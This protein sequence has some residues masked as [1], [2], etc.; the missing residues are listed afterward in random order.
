MR[1]KAAPTITGWIIGVLVELPGEPAPARHFFAVAQP[2]RA[3]AEWAAAD[4]AMLIGAI[5][6]SPYRS[7]EPVDALG[8]LS[9]H[10]ISQLGLA[11]GELKPL[12]RKWPRRWLSTAIPQTSE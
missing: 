10:A 3:L 12:G 4:R 1:P 9:A 5:A 7:M 11:K 2:D 6:A 8:E